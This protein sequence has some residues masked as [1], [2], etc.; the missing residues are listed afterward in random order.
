MKFFEMNLVTH[1][2]LI[3]AAEGLTNFISLILE[4]TQYLYSIYLVLV[5]EFEFSMLYSDFC[6]SLWT[7]Q[8]LSWW[9]ELTINCCLR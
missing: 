7:L 2:K 9:M 8:R 5:F 1:L 3:E 6:L 4:E